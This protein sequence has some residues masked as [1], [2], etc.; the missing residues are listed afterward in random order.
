MKYFA[1][2]V[3]NLVTNIVVVDK[4]PAIDTNLY[5]ETFRDGTKFNFAAIG[6]SYDAT[7]DAFIHKKPFPS[8]ILNET[9]CLWESPIVYPEDGSDL[10]PY[11]W[12]ESITNWKLLS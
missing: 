8:W 12:N 4:I 5:V 1:K 11:K 9:T 10:K 7:R 2:I 6:G 3:D